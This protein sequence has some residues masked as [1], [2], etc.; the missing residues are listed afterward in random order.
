MTNDSAADAALAWLDGIVANTGDPLSDAGVWMLTHES[1]RREVAAWLGL[2][3]DLGAEWNITTLD[4]WQTVARL[5]VLRLRDTL[6]PSMQTMDV[7]SPIGL[8]NVEAPASLDRVEVVFSDRGL[9]TGDYY[10]PAGSRVGFALIAA[11]D[12][13]GWT[14]ASV[15]P[16]W[17]M[18]GWLVEL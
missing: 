16:D 14:I 17:R 9:E 4:D 3:A 6:P 12:A 8:T 5:A 11:H 13:D 15:E 7:G 2:D 1:W 18:P 10:P